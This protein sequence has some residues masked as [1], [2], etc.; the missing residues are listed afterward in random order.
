MVC[1]VALAVAVG[2]LVCAD[3]PA[4]GKKHTGVFFSGYPTAFTLL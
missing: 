3:K 4:A 1:C 2:L